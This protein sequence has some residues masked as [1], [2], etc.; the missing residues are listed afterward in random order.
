MSKITDYPAATTIEGEDLLLLDGVKGTRKVT[1]QAAANAFGKLYG[2][3]YS[4]EISQ[5]SIQAAL[6]EKGWYRFLET[7][8]SNT[9]DLA[10][11]SMLN[12][13]FTLYKNWKND[14]PESHK[15]IIG[16]GPEKKLVLKQILNLS[17]STPFLGK[18]RAYF[19]QVENLVKICLDLYYNTDRDNNVEIIMDNHGLRGTTNYQPIGLKKQPDTPVLASGTQITEWSLKANSWMDG[20][21]AWPLS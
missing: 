18:I 21:D 15:F 4:S 7:S 3:A 19:S 14:R 10:S 5:A 6:S 16:V 2:A 9:V 8:G 1:G 17:Y 20:A 11:G 13:V 12:S